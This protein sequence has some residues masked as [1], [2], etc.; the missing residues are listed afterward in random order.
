MRLTVTLIKEILSIIKSDWAFN[1]RRLISLIE[2]DY[3]S[4]E[5]IVRLIHLNNQ[6]FCGSL[7]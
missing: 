6:I 7:Y 1:M 2:F 3:V 4:V 5:E